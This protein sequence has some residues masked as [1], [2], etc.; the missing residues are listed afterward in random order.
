MHWLPRTPGERL[1]LAALCSLAGHGALWLYLDALPP[2]QV[3]GAPLQL[4][5]TAGAQ[6]V[7][8]PPPLPPAAMVPDAP[9]ASSLVPQAE[10]APR[11]PDVA[12]APAGAVVAGADAALAIPRFYTAAELDKLAQPLQPVLLPDTDSLPEG[13]EL[14]V[15]IDAAGTVLRV[16]VPDSV[17]PDYADQVRQRFLQA[18]FSPAEKDGLPVASVKRIALSAEDL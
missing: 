6:A 7:R 5:L 15:Y 10:P 13:V 9:P 2:Q 17:P 1:L 4:R 3:A 16:E 18:G 8:L 12:D 14:Q 11:A